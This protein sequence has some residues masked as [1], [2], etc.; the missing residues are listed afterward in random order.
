MA[1][2]R[3]SA[4]TITDG[5]KGFT[6][7]VLTGGDIQEAMVTMLEGITD[8]FL[9][10]ALDAAFKPLEDLL[11]QNFKDFFGVE[12]PTQALQAENNAALSA[13]TAALNSVAAA[14]G[15]TGAAG[16]VPIPVE[17]YKPGAPAGGDNPEAAANGAAAQSAQQAAEATNQQAEAN[18]KAAESAKG[19]GQG[20]AGLTN[21]IGGLAG[22]A[23]GAGAIAGGVG[24]M[25]KGGTYNTLMGLAGIFGGIGGIAG[26]FTGF[27]RASGGPVSANRPYIVGEQGP[28]LF[29]PAGNGTI[30]SNQDL[31]SANRGAMG[32]ASAGGSDPFSQ[33]RSAISYSQAAMERRTETERAQRAVS[34]PSPIDIRYEASVI[35]NVEYVTTDQFRSGLN[36]AAERG[37]ALAYN[38]IQNSTKVRSRLG[39]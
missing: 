1:L 29:S 19:A 37:R 25:G 23:A 39:V 26:G 5:F 38:G 13:N 20:M 21:V 14:L 11:A 6:K 2:I 18:K 35:N 27:F 12:D 3:D 24:M 16:P 4:R 34:N 17:P 22:I 36:Q 28:E 33:N 10:M 9:N 8:K 15:G 7:T 32:G 30:T 31:F